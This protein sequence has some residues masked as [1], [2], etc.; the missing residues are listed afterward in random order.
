MKSYQKCRIELEHENRANLKFFFKE[1]LLSRGQTL[2][3]F[4]IT[5]C[6]MILLLDTGTGSIGMKIR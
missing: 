2:L 3:T 4:M 1:S 5:T 6:Y